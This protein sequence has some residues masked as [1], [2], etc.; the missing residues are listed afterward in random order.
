MALNSPSSLF[1]CPQ[2]ASIAWSSVARR[3]AALHPR[4]IWKVVA[5]GPVSNISDAMGDARLPLWRNYVA[6]GAGI[7]E[8]STNYVLAAKRRVGIGGKRAMGEG[9]G[10]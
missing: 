7:G 4:I 8:A 3:V 1:F 5:F 10:G 6:M 9:D 2:A